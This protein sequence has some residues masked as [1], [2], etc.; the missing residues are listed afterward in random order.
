MPKMATWGGTWFTVTFINSLCKRLLNNLLDISIVNYKEK[1][2]S[3]FSIIISFYVPL[4][5][6][7]IR[8]SIL[9]WKFPVR[10]ISSLVDKCIN[11]FFIAFPCSYFFVCVKK[12]VTVQHILFCQFQFFHS[13]CVSI[14]DVFYNIN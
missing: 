9:Y 7:L 4:K 10:K 12:I 13:F 2:H 11:C 3:R 1:W 5:F 8:C 14:F 6:F